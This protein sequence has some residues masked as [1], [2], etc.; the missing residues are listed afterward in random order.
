MKAG[1]PG[2]ELT[3]AGWLQALKLRGVLES[4]AF[5]ATIGSRNIEPYVR[6]ATRTGVGVFPESCRSR[7]LWPLARRL[8]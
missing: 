8:V 1:P 3:G 5:Q 7:N 6:E 2:Y 4:E